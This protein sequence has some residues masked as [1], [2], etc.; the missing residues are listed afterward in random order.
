MTQTFRA[1]QKS[2]SPKTSSPVQTS[3]FANRPFAEPVQQK[4][5]QPNLQTILQRAERAGNPIS[6]KPIQKQEESIPNQTGLPDNLKAGVENLSGY[7]LDDVRVHYNSPKPAQLQ[8][9]AYTQGTEIHVA[10]GQEKHIPHEA[11]HVVQQMQGRVKPTMQ[12]KGVQIND[13]EEL[14][15][16]ADVVGTRATQMSGL[17]GVQNGR[18]DPEPSPV[19]STAGNVA[20]LTTAELQAADDI[21][22]AYN[23]THVTVNGIVT[24][25]I[26][27]LQAAYAH[28]LLPANGGLNDAAADAANPFLK[29]S[30]KG[31]LHD[32]EEIDS[33]SGGYYFQQVV[34]D[35]KNAAVNVINQTGAY[36]GASNISDPDLI[37][38]Q[39]AGGSKDAIEVKRTTTPNGAVPLLD[40]ALMQLS[41]R[42]GYANASVF[43]EVTDPTQSDT[44]IADK[45]FF[46]NRI[47]NTVQ[48]LGRGFSQ[49]YWDS[50]Q[51]VYDGG[52]RFT[53]TVCIR[54]S[55]PE[56]PP[57]I[58][59]RDFNVIIYQGLGRNGAN[60]YT[61]NRPTLLATRV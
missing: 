39:G 51:A 14:E 48:T 11:W 4:A 8:A 31:L 46:D 59:D 37:V 53:L 28:Y 6:E 58:Y 19:T 45:G 61:L 20:Q 7:S 56:A 26:A 32:V 3:Q 23:N 9:L 16:E 60:I 35:S 43:I 50:S 27:R 24:G 36:G 42:K 52:R 22:Q 15:R 17:D 49:N 29:N 2:K 44:I 18:P 1:G 54:S 47:E 13:N 21:W 30:V 38:Q 41:V 33:H 57:V 40:S 34:K 5:Q 10:P 55:V 25:D 12:M